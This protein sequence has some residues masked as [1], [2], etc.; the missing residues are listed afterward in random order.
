MLR[1]NSLPTRLFCAAVVFVSLA[2]AALAAVTEDP[3]QVAWTKQIGTAKDDSS[4]SVAVDVSGNVYISGYTEGDL[5]GTNAGGNDA[6]LTKFDSSG[7]ELWSKQIGTSDS[8][9]SRSVAVDGFG[10]AYI[11]GYTEGDLGG[12]NAGG[13]DAFLTKFD[14]SGDELW[15]QQ[16]GSWNHDFSRSVAVDAFGNAYISGYTGGESAHVTDAFLTKF[17]NLGNELWT[18]QIGSSSRDFSYSVA[19]DGFGNAYISGETYGDIGGT[20][21]GY[22]DAF[23]TKFDTLGNELWTR[24]IGTLDRDSGFS[25]SVDGFGNAYVTGDT[26]GDLAGINQGNLDIFLAK[27]DAGGD[28]LWTQQIGT[29]GHD[30]STSVAADGSGNI[31]ISGATSGGLAGTNAGGWDAY[32]VKY[33]S[34]GSLLW[35]QQ[36]GSTGYE[37]SDSVVLD[38]LGNVYITGVTDGDL[39]GANAGYGDAFLVKFEAPEPASLALLAVGSFAVLR[40]RKR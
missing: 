24:Q 9:F 2:P 7:N 17:D 36:I 29:S 13:N 14:S 34:S 31:Y 5:G 1:I 40:R 3:Y 21:A 28:L 33:D 15:S 20:S 16:I 19:I 25:V 23:L 4:Q 37:R 27:Y 30:T 26:G 22:R 6:F 35:S 8:D 11:S 38:D 18:Q 39:G 32:L 12:T 10:N